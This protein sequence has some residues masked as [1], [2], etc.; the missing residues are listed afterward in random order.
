MACGFP[1]LAISSLIRVLPFLFLISAFPT[2]RGAMAEPT[3][4]TAVPSL[5]LY[6]MASVLRLTATHC[7]FA[8]SCPAATIWAKLA[9]AIITAISALAKNTL[10]EFIPVIP[11]WD[12]DFLRM[13][14]LIMS[15]IQFDTAAL[16]RQSGR[17]DMNRQARA[18]AALS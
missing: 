14:I 9:T 3:M 18:C 13:P 5:F 17:R 7:E 4:L 10:F 2:A 1:R 15:A 6:P 12:L 8:V 11:P 16:A